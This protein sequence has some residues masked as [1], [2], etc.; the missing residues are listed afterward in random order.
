M[1]A[2]IVGAESYPTKN[3]AMPRQIL[4]AHLAAL[5]RRPEFKDCKFMLIPEANLGNEAQR[6][7]QV[8]LRRYRDVEVLCE[9]SHCYGVF[10][11]P[12]DPEKYAQRL[13]DKLAE[14]GL[15]FH[16]HVTCA[17]PYQ[18]HIAYADRLDAIMKELKRQLTSFRKIHIVPANLSSKVH[19]IFS[20]KADKD[21]KRSNRTKDDMVMALLFGYYYYTQ[22]ISPHNLVSKRDSHSMLRIETMGGTVLEGGREVAADDDAADNMAARRRHTRLSHEL[23]DGRGGGNKRRRM[24]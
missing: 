9:K 21:N 15:F 13:D 8:S 19:V 3:A 22:F 4:Y 5:R 14:D 18:A 23:D 12:Y 2:Q 10:T 11:K 1:R 7:A 17:N 6:L 16:A 20:G 24:S